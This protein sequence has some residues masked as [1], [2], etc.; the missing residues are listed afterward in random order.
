MSTVSERT[1][2]ALESLNEQYRSATALLKRLPGSHHMTA[3]VFIRDKG[4]G[5]EERLEFSDCVDKRGEAQP[6]ICVSSY[7]EVT[8]DRMS[9][10]SVFDLPVSRRIELAKYVAELIQRARHAEGSV[11]EEA[12]AAAE[13][14]KQAIADASD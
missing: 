9:Q 7:V 6:A 14:L 1:G 3:S 10:V 13:T 11:A 8:M 4:D 2:R 12:E 5:T